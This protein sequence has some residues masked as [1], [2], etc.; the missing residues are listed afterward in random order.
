MIIDKI[1]QHIVQ[2]TARVGKLEA[3][4]HLR[5]ILPV[6][7][8]PGQDDEPGRIIFVMIDGWLQHL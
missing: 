2:G 6:Y 7:G 5:R 4:A 8:I 1:A 3:D